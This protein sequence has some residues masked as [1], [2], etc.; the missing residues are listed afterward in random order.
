MIYPPTPL[1]DAT[2]ILHHGICLLTSKEAVGFVS[3]FITLF[4]L[5]ML[6]FDTCNY[7][8]HKATIKMQINVGKCEDENF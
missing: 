8:T 4:I 6:K 1:D 3:M 2:F 7:L 5:T